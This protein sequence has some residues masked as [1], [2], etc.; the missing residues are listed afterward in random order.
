M[1]VCVFWQRCV[2]KQDCNCS[3]VAQS[4]PTFGISC[5]SPGG[6][7]FSEALLIGGNLLFQLKRQQA[8]NLTFYKQLTQRTWMLLDTVGVSFPVLPSYLVSGPVSE[9]N[10]LLLHCRG[11]GVNSYSVAGAFWG[12][13][14]AGGFGLNLEVSMGMMAGFGDR[15]VSFLGTD[16][17]IMHRVGEAEICTWKSFPFVLLASNVLPMTIPTSHSLYANELS[18]LPPLR[19]GQQAGEKEIHREI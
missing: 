5:N 15:M 2:C 14:T 19:V 12:R 18:Q 1:C 9:A 8:F 10:W 13:G 6:K 3:F 11:P 16:E 7:G 17:I 4:C